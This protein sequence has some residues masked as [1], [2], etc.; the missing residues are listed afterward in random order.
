MRKICFYPPAQPVDP[1][2]DALLLCLR[3]F[4]VATHF[5]VIH[6]AIFLQI[7]FGLAIQDQDQDQDEE[8]QP[9]QEEQGQDEQGYNP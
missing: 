4:V 2:M 8:Y 7:L 1:T 6:F 5:Q 3:L 9:E